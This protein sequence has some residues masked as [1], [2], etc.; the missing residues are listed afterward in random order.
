MNTISNVQT[1]SH[2]SIAGVTFN[3]NDPLNIRSSGVDVPGKIPYKV[4]FGSL[5]AQ[6]FTLISRDDLLF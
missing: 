1:G 2:I 3:L 6:N 5:S 4:F